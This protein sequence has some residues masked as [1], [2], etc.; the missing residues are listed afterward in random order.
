MLAQWIQSRLLFWLLGSVGGCAVNLLA[1]PVLVLLIL[2]AIVSALQGGSLTFASSTAA[3]NSTPS[4]MTQD[5]TGEQN[6]AVVSA[7]LSMTPYLSNDETSSDQWYVTG[8]PQA[9]LDYW[10]SVCPSG[11]DCWA[12]WQEG[13]LQCV[14]FVTAAYTLAGQTLPYAGNA[15]DFWAGYQD[16][17]GWQE[18]PNGSQNGPLP[19]D[20]IVWSDGGLGHVAIAL[21]VKLPTNENI[22]GYVTFGEANGPTPIVQ[23]PLILNSAGKL[24]MLTWLGYDVLGY[25]RHTAF[26]S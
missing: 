1:V 20:I 21:D 11:S 6:Q 7:A 3:Q 15:I 19:G 16:R 9:A 5:W 26:V 13:Q 17:S 12:N 23:E 24:V 10:A 4:T 2:L 14:E 22:S 18:I 25:I 8:F